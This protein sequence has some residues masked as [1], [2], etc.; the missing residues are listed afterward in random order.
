MLTTLRDAFKDVSN[1]LA[2]APKGVAGA[3]V[4]A[5]KGGV[6][7]ST[8]VSQGC[9]PV[10]EPWTITGA[11][12]NFMLTLGSQPVTPLEMTDSYATIAAG[13]IHHP[14]QALEL[15]RD[16]AGKVLARL[17]PQGNR[18]ISPNTGISNRPMGRHR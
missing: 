12:E 11:E 17:V 3:L 1:A 8:I 5:L 2:F 16:P 10:G 7:V 9:R 18:V 4:L 14:A 13:G 15:V 6:R